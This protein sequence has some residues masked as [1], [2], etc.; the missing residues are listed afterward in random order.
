MTQSNKELLASVFGLVRGIRK[1][2]DARASAMDMTYARAQALTHI[3]ANEGLTQVELAAILDIRTPTMNRT[4]DHLEAAKL[5]ERRTTREDK[6]VRQLFL[7]P[8][9]HRQADRIVSFTHELREEAYRGIPP[10]EV[11]QALA[12]LRRI[13]A[14]LDAMEG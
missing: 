4:L 6:R 7:T 1:Q 12:T 10:E 11:E 13:Q 5:I 2:F 14:N 3:A 8:Q 9:A